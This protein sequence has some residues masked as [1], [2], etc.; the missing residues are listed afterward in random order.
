MTLD[1]K[2]IGTAVEYFE[3]LDLDTEN[4][5][6]W[7]ETGNTN[8]VSMNEFNAIG[9]IIS[10]QVSFFCLRR[11][12]NSCESVSDSIRKMLKEKINNYELDYS[13]KFDNCNEEYLW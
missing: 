2:I 13:K 11:L 4:D 3:R 10:L 5:I 9:D 8:L 12:S 1:S 7:D 6:D